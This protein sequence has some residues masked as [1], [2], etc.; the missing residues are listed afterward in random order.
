MI[1]R[2]TKL[3]GV[4]D[5]FALVLDQETLDALGY[6]TETEVELRVEEGSLVIEPAREAEPRGSPP[7]PAGVPEP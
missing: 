2:R 5:E 6:S 7:S 4:G 3:T 1:T